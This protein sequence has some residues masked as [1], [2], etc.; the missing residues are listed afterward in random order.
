MSKQE[1]RPSGRSDGVRV[2]SFDR[3]VARL[4]YI[5][6]HRARSRASGEPCACTVCGEGFSGIYQKDASNPLVQRDGVAESAGGDKKGTDSLPSDNGD[7][8]NPRKV[9]WWQNKVSD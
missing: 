2:L 4:A 9:A 7:A 6:D 8:K 3:T 1:N 5:Q